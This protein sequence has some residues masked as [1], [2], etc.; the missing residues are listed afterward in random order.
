MRGPHTFDSMIAV[1]LVG[2]IVAFCLGIHVVAS[3]MG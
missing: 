3:L 1:L 2:A